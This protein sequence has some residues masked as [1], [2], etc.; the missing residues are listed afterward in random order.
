MKK[1]PHLIPDKANCTF[2]WN[3]YLNPDLAENK[4]PLIVGYSKF[5]SHAEAND[6]QAVLMAKIEMF[7]KN[8]YLKKCERI[9]IY[10][11]LGPLP[12]AQDDRLVLTL[13]PTDFI[14]PTEWIKTFPFETKTFL[15]NF[16]NAIT[17]GLE[18]KNLRPLPTK[19]SKDDNLY[20]LI[21][22]RFLTFSDLQT[23]CTKLLASGEAPGMVS[24]FK[25]KY[26]KE[27]LEI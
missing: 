23:Y 22:G 5:Q 14:I 4:V 19:K 7:Y 13:K 17:N 15:S 9:E 24:G 8:G 16:Y 20:S 6:K 12:S 11:K 25:Y 3:I 18:V 1:S 21:K 26:Q 2:W 10:K 27:F